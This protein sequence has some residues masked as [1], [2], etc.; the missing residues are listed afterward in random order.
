M[1]SAETRTKSDVFRY[2]RITGI[3][4][5]IEHRPPLGSFWGESMK[6]A[7]RRDIPVG[8]ALSAIAL[9]VYFV[10]MLIWTASPKP[11]KCEFDGTGQAASSDRLAPNSLWRYP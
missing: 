10:I 2:I 4:G 1:F 7:V 5:T 11:P 8:V 6:G 9:S 3:L